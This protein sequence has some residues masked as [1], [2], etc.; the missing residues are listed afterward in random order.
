[1]LPSSAHH[2]I[3]SGTTFSLKVQRLPLWA[4]VGWLTEERKHPQ[5]LYLSCDILYRTQGSSAEEDLAH[6]LDYEALIKFLRSFAHQNPG[7]RLLETLVVITCQTLLENFPQI[8][9]VDLHIEKARMPGRLLAQG[10]KVSVGGSY[11]RSQPHSH[12]T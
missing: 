9:K 5:Q 6:F 1:M 2:G 10:G 3:P 7:T 11:S 8:L 4:T 12:P